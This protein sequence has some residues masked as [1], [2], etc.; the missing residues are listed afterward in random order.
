MALNEGLRPETS[1]G[2]D[3]MCAGKTPHTSHSLFERA[4]LC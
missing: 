3:S 1:R 4:I 2:K